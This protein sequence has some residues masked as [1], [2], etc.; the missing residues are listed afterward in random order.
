MSLK[1]K[2]KTICGGGSGIPPGGKTGQVL[3]KG[4]DD[5]Y[6]TYWADV[7]GSVTPPDHEFEPSY[8]YGYDIV[9]ANED[10]DTRVIYPE[11]VYNFGFTP[12][13][14]N[15]GANFSYGDWTISPGEK[16]MPKPCML[17]FDGIVGYYLNPDNY[18]QKEN[19]EPSDINDFSC[20]GNA[21][22]EWPKIYTKRW[23][24]PDGVYH[25]RC[26]DVKLDNDYECWCNYDIHDNEITH[27]YTPIYFGSLDM[28]NRLRSISGKAN[29]IS[30]T[31]GQEINYA[32][33]NGNDWYTEVVA[34]RF[35]IQD[36]LVMMFKSTNLQGSL[37]Y[38]VCNAPSPAS[39]GMMDD[40]GLFWGSRNQ[41]SGVKAF[42]MEHVWGN[43]WRRVAG[44]IY[45]YGQ[46][47]V[48][49]TR[50][51]KDG[52]TVADYNLTG[53][54]YIL[55]ENS[56]VIGG[57]SNIFGYINKMITEDYGRIPVEL[58]GSNST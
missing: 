54:G 20:N 37:G 49:L 26:S 7:E 13:R 4:S 3:T 12:A 45:S 6:D 15:F 33:A 36:L 47:K 39:S 9:L 48:K 53:D 14:M 55:I 43:L 31:A 50:G 41:D 10:P 18:L 57:S 23:E 16:F 52:T 28:Q 11:A 58:Y 38:G 22:M 32:K 17:Q 44:W 5:D 30:T 51:T 42:G 24:T 56:S 34:D 46:Q 8:L 35:L 2:G 1:Y 21:M 25:F 27:F 29:S 40:K 19:G